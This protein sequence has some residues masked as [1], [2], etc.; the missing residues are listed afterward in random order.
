MTKPRS[1]ATGATAQTPDTLR[2]LAIRV[3]FQ[4]DTLQETNGT[5]RFLMTPPDEPTIDPAPHD[6]AYFDAQLQALANYFA[7]VSRNKLILTWNIYP[8][9]NTGSYTLPRKMNYYAPGKDSA[10]ADQRL[11][12]LFRDAFTQ[13]DQQDDIDF[14]HYDSFILFHAGVGSDLNFDFDP[15]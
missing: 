4:P 11:A 8:Q 13:A 15:T 10:N 7:T 2:I 9:A 5:G 1:A 14:S 6:R 12:E 3:E